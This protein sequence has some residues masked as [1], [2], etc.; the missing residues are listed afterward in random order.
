MAKCS[1][2]YT[3]RAIRGVTRTCRF[4]DIL[5]QVEVTHAAIDA[6]VSASTRVPLCTIGTA[7]RQSRRSSK[8]TR[9]VDGVKLDIITDIIIRLMRQKM[10]LNDEFLKFSK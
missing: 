4:S 3:P 8:G 7:K 9:I 2:V 10:Y 1:A 5:G 6:A